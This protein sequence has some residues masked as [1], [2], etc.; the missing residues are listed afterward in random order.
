MEAKLTMKGVFLLGHTHRQ[1]QTR[2]KNKAKLPQ[3]PRNN[4]VQTDDQEQY[5]I[6]KE[7]DQKYNLEVKPGFGPT[8]VQRKN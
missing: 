5:E 3:V 6:A 2:D 1:R 7:L 4:I 8:G